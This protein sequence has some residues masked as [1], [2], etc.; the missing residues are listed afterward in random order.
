MPGLL[1]TFLLS[2]AAASSN[3]RID[4]HSHVVP[5]IW[6]DAMIEAGYPVQNGSLYA[7]GFPVPDWTL[8]DH[9]A[10]MDSLGVNYSTISISAPGVF[11]IKDPSK[12]QALARSI[13]LEM[14]TYTTQYPD[15]LGALCLLPLPHVQESL[16]ELEHCLTTLHFPGAATFTNSAGTYLGNST[17]DPIFA[18]LRAHNAPVFIHPA[19]P[20]CS[21]VSMGYPVPMTEY[22]F[23]TVRAIENLLLTG[24]RARYPDV[25]MI[26]AHGDG[27]LPYL[28]SRIA[29]MSSMPFL[30]GL[31]VSESMGQLAGYFFDTASATSRV[32]LQALKEFVGV[33][34]LVTGTDYPYVPTTQAQPAVKAIQSNGEFNASAMARINHGNAL[35]I[36]PRVA[37]ILGV[38]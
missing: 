6:K 29:G 12:A 21:A 31:S 8:E 35:G 19:A 22:P 26:F 37:E 9:I 16:V 32:Q 7:D 28:A 20:G 33:G 24:Q 30:G 5:Q 25:R 23:D 10:T 15:R 11:F 27:A 3:Y 18:S 17:L 34:G 4:V 2:A 13:N 1:Q 38:K 14:H 36:F